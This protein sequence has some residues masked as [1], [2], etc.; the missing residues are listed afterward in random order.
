MEAKIIF[1]GDSR[2]FAYCLTD[3]GSDSREIDLFAP[4]VARIHV[5]LHIPRVWQHGSISHI[6]DARDGRHWRS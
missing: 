4:L 2:S 5:A 1:P 3:G 6:G